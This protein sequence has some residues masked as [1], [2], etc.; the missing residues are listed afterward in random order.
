MNKQRGNMYPFV[1]HTWNPVPGCLHDCPYCYVK[2][3]RGYDRTPRV[4]DRALRENL[5]Q[6][7]YIF[8]CST[9]DLFGHWVPDA[10]ILAVLDKCR[11][12]ENTYLFQTK[13]PSRFQTFARLFPVKS[14]LGTTIETNRELDIHGKVGVA[15]LRSERM[16]AMAALQT[17]KMVSIEPI[18]DFDVDILLRWMKAIGP[19]FVSIGADSKGSH[20]PEPS[21][22]KLAALISGLGKITEV[23]LKPNFTRLLAGVE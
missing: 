22:E 4:S 16:A 18:M 11:G 14:V 7:N 23:R 19:T 6:G 2:S 20:L 13:N 1:T 15:P 17:D 3:L 10:W 9:G 12:H 5:G 8:V 21:A